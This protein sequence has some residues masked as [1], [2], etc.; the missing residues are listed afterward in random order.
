VP[1]CPYTNTAVVDSPWDGG[2][3]EKNLSNDAG[4]STYQKVYAWR[5][6]NGDPNLKSS[7]KLPHHEVSSDGTPGAANVNGCNAAKAALHGAR[8][9]TN[10]PTGD[11]GAVEAHLQKHIDKYKGSS[12][13][14]ESSLDVVESVLVFQAAGRAW[15]IQPGRLDALISLDCR[16]M[17]GSIVAAASDMRTLRA[18]SNG[19]GPSNGVAVV[20]LT[21]TLMPDSMDLFALLFGSSPGGL[22]AFRANLRKMAADPD[23]GAIVMNV[24]SPGGVVDQIPE[25]AAEI[26]TVKGI[27]PV[28]AV[29]NTAA[30]SAAYWLASQADQVIVTPS[31]EVGSIGVYNIHRDQ[32]AANEM[33]GIKPTVISAGKYKVEGHPHEPLTDD[34][35]EALQ[36]EVNDYYGM[37]VKD[38]AR[39]RGVTEHAVRNG[40]G[41]GRSLHARQAVEAGLADRVDTLDNTVRRLGTARGRS[42]VTEQKADR[43]AQIADDDEP[44]MELDLAALHGKAGWSPEERSRLL[45][46]LA[47]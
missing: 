39:G 20:P 22:P 17:A 35:R 37:F 2:A 9:G 11:R 3:A 12:S 30:N 29:A 7:Y 27:K 6:P 5:D 10:I 41:E 31:G 45:A 46:V 42:A 18:G 47:G 15:A 40:Y 25:T 4:Q 38:V 19:T 16:A 13:S 44:T 23:V 34:A 36:G 32:S 33:R 1:A 24:D 8:G 43:V 26:R 28:V 21:G 14:S